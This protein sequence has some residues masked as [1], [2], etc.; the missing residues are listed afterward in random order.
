MIQFINQHPIATV[1][2]VIIVCET[3]VNVVKV[4]FSKKEKK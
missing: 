4:V 3:I 2:V 1:F